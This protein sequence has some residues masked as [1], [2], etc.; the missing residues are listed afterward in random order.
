ML[1]L[2]AGEESMMPRLLCACL[3]LGFMASVA[4]AQGR[5][6]AA[7]PCPFDSVEFHKC[8]LEKMKSF[9]PPR[10]ADGK[11][12]F[13]GYWTSHHNGAVWDIEPRKGQGS[14]VPGTTGV[15]VD[16]PGR[17][18][19]YKPEARVKRDQLRE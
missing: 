11:P 6:G 13:H 9:D 17:R 12:D 14:L 15:I 19:P 1:R 16:P 18:I 10:T 3:L 4:T 2:R 5:G 7:G 8:A